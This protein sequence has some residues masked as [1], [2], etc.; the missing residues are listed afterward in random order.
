MAPSI[1]SKYFSALYIHSTHM[2]Q[3]PVS[4]RSVYNPTWC[5]LQLCQATAKSALIS[6]GLKYAFQCTLG[7]PWIYLSSWRVN[8]HQKAWRTSTAPEDFSPK[9]KCPYSSWAPLTVLS[10]NSAMEDCHSMSSIMT[11]QVFFLPWPR[12]NVMLPT[13]TKEKKEKK[14][15]T[16][17]I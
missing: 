9:I 11:S 17:T 14:K 16:V 8:K 7:L 3:V 13:R 6:M 12:R 1:L 4:A 2:S 5:V 15:L 10:W